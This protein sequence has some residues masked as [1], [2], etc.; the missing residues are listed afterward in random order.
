MQCPCIAWEVRERR[1]QPANTERS[2]TTLT[3]QAIASRLPG[4]L[5]SR[6]AGEKRK[7]APRHA[8][9]SAAAFM[10]FARSAAL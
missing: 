3:S 9:H 5:L 4:P 8:N 10:C 1:R 2:R 6:F 7:G